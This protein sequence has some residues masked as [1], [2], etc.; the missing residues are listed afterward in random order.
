MDIR[1]LLSSFSALALGQ[2]KVVWVDQ[3]DMAVNSDHDY[4]YLPKPQGISGES[5]LLLALFFRELG[6]MQFTE[7][8]HP[9][10][11]ERVTALAYAM[12]EARVKQ[13]IM[14]EFKGI[15]AFFESATTVMASALTPSDSD[16]RL[17]VWFAANDGLL[18]SKTSGEAARLHADALVADPVAVAKAMAIATTAP[19][20]ASTNAVE[21]CARRIAELLPD[22]PPQAS[23]PEGE[24]QSN[25]GADDQGQGP[26]TSDPMSEALA[27]LKGQPHCAP[28]NEDSPME[29]PSAAPGDAGV[30]PQAAETL[31]DL[32]E[33]MEELSAES[34]KQQGDGVADANVQP[35]NATESEGPEVS[36][37]APFDQQKP[38]LAEQAGEVDQLGQHGQMSSAGTTDRG[39]DEPSSQNDVVEFTPQ[40]G[41]EGGRV[42]V[43]IN[44]DPADRLLGGLPSKMVSA[45]LRA[46]QD[47]RHVHT[48][49]VETGNRVNVQ[50]FWRLK[51]MGDTRVMASRR[52][53]GGIDA[54]VW[55]LLDVSGSMKDRIDVAVDATHAFMVG[56]Q[57][58][59]GVQVALSVFP[60]QSGVSDQVMGLNQ[61]LTTALTAMKRIT[62]HGSTTPM[63]QAIF[64]VTPHIAESRK[65]RKIVLVIT[66]GK[67]SCGARLVDLARKHASS[68]GVET[69]CVGIKENVAHL[70][71]GCSTSIQDVNELPDA[72][73]HLFK[74]NVIEPSMV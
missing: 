62:A 54:A 45:L 16:P 6:R 73:Q 2:D 50:R 29:N 35:R 31:Q 65:K 41:Q 42:A 13:A 12:E 17:A 28:R 51:A 61:N 47:K 44:H 52:E 59:G 74:R 38:P 7:P 34:A 58:T 11:E 14:A 27:K 18:S 48:R 71:P 36:S 40:A 25:D 23:A 56:L 67:P 64:S 21:N 22:E 33:Q 20:L 9:G 4:I 63:G 60:G 37:D 46:I 70:F 32:I 55:I 10:T 15:K 49:C 39:S 30:D 1:K 57:R 3:P 19:W 72:L 24:A 8:V 43:H 66:D 26:P 5:D 69:V 68:L 53:T